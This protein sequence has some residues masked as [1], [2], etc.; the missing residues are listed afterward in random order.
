MFC[1][2]LY[3]NELIIRQTN[4][5]L[6]KLYVRTFFTV[7]SGISNIISITIAYILYINVL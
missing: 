7:K 3:I 4:A 6:D 1:G 2:K 5:E